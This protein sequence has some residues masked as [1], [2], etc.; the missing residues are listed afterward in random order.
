MA[1]VL[2]DLVYEGLWA[3]R[4]DATESGAIMKWLV[5]PLHAPP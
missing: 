4:R 1:L 2:L 3:W 5:R